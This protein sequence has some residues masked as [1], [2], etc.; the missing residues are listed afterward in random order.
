[1]DIFQIFVYLPRR[2][3]DLVLKRHLTIVISTVRPR[4]ICQ[5][6]IHLRDGATYIKELAWGCDTALN[7]IST[8]R[9]ARTWLAHAM[10][11]YQWRNWQGGKGASRLPW[12]AKC[13]NWAPFSCHFDIWR[14]W[15]CCVFAF[16]GVF[17]VFL[18]II[19]IHDIKVHYSLTFFGMLASDSPTLTSGPPSAKLCP[20]GSNLWL[21]HCLLLIIGERYFGCRH[22]KF[23]QWY[24]KF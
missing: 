19:D 15:G 3:C 10:T 16:F 14:S 22:L 18:A 7:L 12:Q 20:P 17:S 9:I 2:L 5:F 8:R 13:K 24:C 6:V 23:L 11:C 1:V 4:K 21:R